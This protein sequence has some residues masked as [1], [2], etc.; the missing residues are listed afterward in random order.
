MD[1]ALGDGELKE[2][3]VGRVV[4]TRD[5]KVEKERVLSA[6][7]VVVVDW[8][9][10]VDLRTGVCVRRMDMDEGD[11]AVCGTDVG[12]FVPSESDAPKQ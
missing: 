11:E 7:V 10:V 3:V 2:V 5:V 8:A 12:L 9:S 6:V 4:W 1:K